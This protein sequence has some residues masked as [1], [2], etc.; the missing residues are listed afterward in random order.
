MEIPNTT[1]KEPYIEFIIDK[2]GNIKLSTT[3]NWWGGKKGGF[4]CSDGTEGN[5]CEP[6]NLEAYVKAFKTRKIIKFEN[7]IKILQ[8]K[9]EKIKNE[10]YSWEV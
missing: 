8:K 3:S 10:T 5:S 6:K 4:K 7:K 9:L 1:E 2:K